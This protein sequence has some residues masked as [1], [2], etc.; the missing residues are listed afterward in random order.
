M[1]NFRADLALLALA[2]VGV[3]A[4]LACILTNHPAPDLF[5]QVVI[6][7]IAGG[8][9][10]AVQPT[11]SATSTSAPAAP[12]ATSTAPASPTYVQAPVAPAAQAPQQAAAVQPVYNGPVGQ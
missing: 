3:A 6:A 10:I 8:A 2:V 12:V 1:Q 11:G 4:D 9:G 5:A 7:G